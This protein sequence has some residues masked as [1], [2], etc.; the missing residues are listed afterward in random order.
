MVGIQYEELERQTINEDFLSMFG[1]NCSASSTKSL[2]NMIRDNNI[3][4]DNNEGLGHIYI[5]LNEKECSPTQAKKAIIK[6]KRYKINT[7]NDNTMKEKVFS[8]S[9]EYNAND[10]DLSSAYYHNGFLRVISI[11]EVSESQLNTQNTTNK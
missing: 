10:K 1:E 9:N 7:P 4:V 5:L 11:N 3:T 6:G 8:K 2:I